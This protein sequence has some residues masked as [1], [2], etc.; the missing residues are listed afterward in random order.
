MTFSAI[1]YELHR[2]KWFVIGRHDRI[3]GVRLPRFLC[4]TK[5]AKFERGVGREVV[6]PTWSYEHIRRLGIV[7][8]DLRNFQIRILKLD[9]GWILHLEG[10]FSQFAKDI[11]A[12]W[13][14]IDQPRLVG[15]AIAT[16]L[17]SQ[18]PPSPFPFPS[19]VVHDS[20]IA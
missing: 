9:L 8:N 13:F 17:G 11:P 3:A 19:A 16:Y 2:H 15:I 18:L 4:K 7:V 14:C 12:E 5:I 20:L 10:S 1:R 6:V